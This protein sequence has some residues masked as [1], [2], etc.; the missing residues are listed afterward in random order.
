[1]GNKITTEIPSR[2]MAQEIHDHVER[3]KNEMLKDPN[4]YLSFSERRK[5]ESV[6]H[7][8]R[9]QM[10]TFPQ[11]KEYQVYVGHQPLNQMEQSCIRSKLPEDRELIGQTSEDDGI[12]CG[13]HDPDWFIHVK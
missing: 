9:E 1:M 6:L 7:L 10:I 13:R 3:E 4:N 12:D 5:C 8:L 2:V 11:R